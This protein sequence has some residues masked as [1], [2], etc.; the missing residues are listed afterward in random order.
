MDKASKT[1]RPCF[2]AFA[3]LC[4]INTPNRMSVTIMLGRGDSNGL[5]G[6]RPAHHTHGTW[7][8][9][10]GGV[11]KMLPRSC[12]CCLWP[13]RPTAWWP[14]GAEL[15]TTP[16]PLSSPCSDLPDRVQAPHLAFETFYTRCHLLLSPGSSHAVPAEPTAPVSLSPPG[17]SSHPGP[18]HF[19]AKSTA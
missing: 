9:G 10:W 8:W 13:G 15:P 3:S 18:S 5:L 1:A 17:S 7:E 11:M 2:V 6:A 16:P 4:C 12:G 19:Q 14:Q